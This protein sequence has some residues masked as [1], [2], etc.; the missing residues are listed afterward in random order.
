MAWFLVIGSIPGG[1]VGLLFEQRIEALFH[2]AVGHIANSSMV[3]MAMIIAI[4]GAL[5]FL[6]ERL[7]RHERP[8]NQ[9]GLKDVILIGMAQ[10]LAI[11]PGVSRSGSTLT[12]GLA[13]G[14]RR[15]S[16]AKFSFLLSAPIVAGAGIKSV[17]NLYKGVNTGTITSAELTLFPIGFLVAGLSGFLC[18]K[19]LLRFLQNHSTNP[20]VYYRWILALVIIAVTFFRT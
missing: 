10:A 17:W 6:A 7:A 19:Y 4:L 8:L 16:A 2:P 1:I 9:I 5:L 12:C 11:F 3:V 15:E 20:F 14:L 18:I 13:L